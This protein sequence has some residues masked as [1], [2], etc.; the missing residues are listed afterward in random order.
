[1]ELVVGSSGRSGSPPDERGEGPNF[2]SE[3]AGFAIMPRG[4]QRRTLDTGLCLDIN[5]L[6]RAGLRNGTYKA[7]IAV[8]GSP[9]EGEL[10]IC[11]DD[12]PLRRMEFRFPGFNHTIGLTKVPRP[13]GG[14]QWYFFCPMTGDRASVLWLP[15]GENVFAS[16][17]YWKGRGMAYRSQFLSPTDRADRGI[18]TIE[19]R[20]VYSEADN[21]HYKPK[22]MR[23][24][25]FHRLCERLDAYEDVLNDRLIRGVARLMAISRR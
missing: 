24:R 20:L 3:T 22:W 23:W 15:R 13:F 14:F 21:M 18:K 10:T 1:L 9:V 12:G 25:T 8:H 6:I 7:R 16:Q 11:M 17:K 4:R 2:P 19:A 5:K